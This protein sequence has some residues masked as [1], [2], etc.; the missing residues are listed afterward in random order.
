MLESEL[1]DVD[2]FNNLIEKY[3]DKV[4]IYFLN[5]LEEDMWYWH[6]VTIFPVE[7]DIVLVLDDY[8]LGYETCIPIKNRFG[9]LDIKF[10]NLNELTHYIDKIIKEN[11]EH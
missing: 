1:F 4:K 7:S 2:P 8:N 6:D 5:S 3:K 11:Y 9:S 10:K